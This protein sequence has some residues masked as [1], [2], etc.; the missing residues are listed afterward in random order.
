MITHSSRN[1]CQRC[2]QV[3]IPPFPVHISTT[4]RG[5]TQ[6]ELL[7]TSRWGAHFGAAATE[8]VRCSPRVAPAGS[9]K[10]RLPRVSA[11][12]FREHPARARHRCAAGL[13]R[14]DTGRAAILASARPSAQGG[15]ACALGCSPHRCA[16]PPRV[17]G[18]Y[19]P[20]HPSPSEN[21]RRQTAMVSAGCA[22]GLQPSPTG[23]STQSQRASMRRSGRRNRQASQARRHT[24]LAI[25]ESP[26]PIR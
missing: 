7:D 8:R 6:P 4:D 12:S 17:T 23:N 5:A 9:P 13:G 26:V 2:S 14:T 10:P 19:A 15:P 16:G 1:G 11:R 22:P 3:T 24:A 18:A 21:R 20:R 25:R